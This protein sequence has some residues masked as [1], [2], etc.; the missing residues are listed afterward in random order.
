MEQEELAKNWAD[1]FV[2]EFRERSR[3]CKVSSRQ[4]EPK[5]EESDRPLFDKEMLVTD[6]KEPE[7]V[8]LIPFQVHGFWTAFHLVLADSEFT[9]LA[10]SFMMAF[11]VSFSRGD[12]A[13]AAGGT[14]RKEK[15]NKNGSS[16]SSRRRKKPWLAQGPYLLSTMVIPTV[17]GLPRL[18]N[19]L[20]SF[21]PPRSQQVSTSSNNTSFHQDFKFWK[22]SHMASL[23]F[24]R[25][26]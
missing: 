16:S 9:R 14:S 21:P 3:D 17:L 1:K 22:C 6:E 15:K 4:R 26:L 8:Q 23:G 11:C 7:F 5:M 18:I 19:H 13:A 24:V 20:A 10:I 2:N 12:C 25:E